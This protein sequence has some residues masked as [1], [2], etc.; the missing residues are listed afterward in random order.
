MKTWLITGCSTGIGRGIARAVL[1]SGDQAIVT[2][3]NIARI[4]D[5]AVDYPDMCLALSLDLTDTMSMERAVASAIERFGRIDVLVN[6]AGYGYRAA[7][8]ESEDQ[9]IDRLFATNVFGPTR[10]MKLCLPQ[11]RKNRSGIIINVSSIGAVRAAVGNGFYSASK[12]A[13]ELVSDALG[14]EVAHL[15]IHVIT[16]EPGAF[17]TSFYDSLHGTRQVIEEYTQSV[18]HMR[19]ENVVNHHDQQGNP[20]AAGEVIVDLIAS[21][22]L[23]CRLPLGSDAVRIIEGELK[24]RL[25]ELTAWE[26]C[27]NRTDY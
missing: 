3:R 18:G 15:G 13:L 20:D 7:I 22:K 8:E 10:L 24:N 19:L 4:E 9:E 17:R 14:K 21:G 23:P 2:A 11:M 26:E 1:K 6:N 5:F 27:S 25:N 12:A 16:V